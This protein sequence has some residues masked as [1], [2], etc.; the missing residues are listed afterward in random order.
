MQAAGTSL[1]IDMDRRVRI[2]DVQIILGS[3]RGADLRVLTDKAPALAKLRLQASAS[4]AGVTLQLS[5][6]RPEQ[7]RCLLIWFTLLSPDSS[8][9]FRAAVYNVR[10]EG[11]S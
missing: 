4:D 1:L 8:G 6:A 2:T 10:L 7:A 3:A 11:T 9:T 5:L